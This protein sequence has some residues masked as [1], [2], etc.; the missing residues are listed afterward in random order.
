MRDGCV[1]ADFQQA[2]AREGLLL[3]E[4]RRIIRLSTPHHKILQTRQ[5]PAQPHPNRSNRHL[6]QAKTPRTIILLLDH[7]RQTDQEGPKA[8]PEALEQRLRIRPSS[9]TSKRRR[10]DP[11]IETVRQ[12]VEQDHED[13]E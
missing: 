1:F 5:D 4:P 2:R 12:L 7:C 11:P 3:V 10:L 13:R 9:L 8:Q 6:G